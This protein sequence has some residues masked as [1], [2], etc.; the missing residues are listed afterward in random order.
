MLLDTT[1][2]VDVLRGHERAVAYV[3]ALSDPPVV[4][5]ITVGELYAGVRSDEEDELARFLSVFRVVPVNKD[6]ARQGGY[7]RRK[8]GPSDGTSLTA[9]LIA[10]TAS[11]EGLDLATHNTKHFP[12]LEGV[13]VPY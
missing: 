7:W 1:I 5:V 3:E 2:L 12:M 10:A 13:H 11:A 9:A 6:I 8:Y 4:S